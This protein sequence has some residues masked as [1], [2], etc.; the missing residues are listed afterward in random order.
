MRADFSVNEGAGDRVVIGGRGVYLCATAEKMTS[1]FV[2]RVHGR[3]GH[4]SMPS[5]ADNALVKAAPLIDRLGA[6]PA[7]PRLIPEVGGV[8]P[9]GARGRC[10]RRPTR[11]QRRAA[12]SPLAGE[13]VEP[14][15]GDDRRADEGARLRE[16]ERHPG[17]LRGHDRLRLLPGQRPRRP[18]RRSARASARRL[19]ARQPRAAGRHAVGDRRAAVGRGRVVRRRGGARR[20]GGAD[21][22]RGLHRLAL[23]A[24][25]VR[26]GRLRVL[27]GARDGRRARGAADPLGGRARAGLGPRARRALAAAR[28]PHRLRV[29]MLELH[30]R[31][32]LRGA[33]GVPRRGAPPGL[34]AD[35]YLGYG[36]ASRLRRD[37]RRRR[38]SRARCRSSPAGPAEA[39]APP[40]APGAFASAS[41]SRPGP[42]TTTRRRSRRCA[43][44]SRA[45]TSTR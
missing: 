44:R 6:L 7:E 37:R 42:P 22:R 5:I 36:S 35:L 9:G 2:L 31:G 33:R 45:A 38:P 30:E 29:A 1:P 12:V 20:A 11:W 39:D 13:L 16:A 10:P 18:R 3:S 23:A 25:G 41:G 21:V 27:P 24:R 4:A 19:R 40:V 28:G 43:R 34:V 26:H 14:L 17:A 8:P 32:R 15:L